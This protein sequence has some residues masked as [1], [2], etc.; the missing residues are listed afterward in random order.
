MR[1]ATDIGGTFTDL[2][3]LDEASGEVGLAKSSSTPPHFSDEERRRIADD[4][5]LARE[6]MD[7]GSGARVV[8]NPRDHARVE[9]REAGL[10][11][12][13]DG[14]ADLRFEVH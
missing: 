1:L 10:F 5:G 7:V 2:V 13:L 6:L 9:R 11:W 12:T 4:A 8:H 3:Y 14:H